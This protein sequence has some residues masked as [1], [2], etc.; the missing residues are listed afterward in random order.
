VAYTTYKSTISFAPKTMPKYLQIDGTQQ[1]ADLQQQYR[2]LEAGG[3]QDMVSRGLTG[4]T[5]LPTMRMGYQREHQAALNRLNESLQQR[6]LAAYQQYHQ[7]LMQQQ[8]MAMDAARLAM[9]QGPAYLPSQKP[10]ATRSAYEIPSTYVLPGSYGALAGNRAYR[11][12]G[13]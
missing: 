9:G 8:A 11:R 3:V 4:S 5:I 1:R 2:N 10:I 7:Q 12:L 6:Q 13:Y